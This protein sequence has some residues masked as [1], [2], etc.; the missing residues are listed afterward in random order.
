[1]KKVTLFL[2]IVILYATFLSPI[3]LFALKKIG[4]AGF[5]FLSIGVGARATGMGEAFTQVGDDVNAIFYN[6]AGIAKM[7]DK[8]NFMANRTTWVADISYNAAGLVINLENLGSFGLSVISS[9]YGDIIGTR[10]SG[11]LEGF[12][13][14]GNLD[15]GAFALS[16]AYARQMTDKFT[17]GG[18]IKYCYQHLGENLLVTNEIEEN[19]ASGF[20]YDFG[21][22]FYPGF[23]SFRLGMTITNFSPQFK[24]VEYSFQL[25]LTFKIGFAMDIL[26]LFGEHVGNSFILSV[27]AIHPRDYEERIHIGGE[28]LLMDMLAIRAGYKFNYDVE[29]LTAGIGLITPPLAGTGLA[30]K[31]DYAYSSLELFGTVNRF[32]LGITF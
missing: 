21:T 13:E 20:S 3:H 19:K 10:V 2:T 5:K 7:H 17:A 23:K 27:D 28:Y 18:Q 24:Y 25:P 29:G 31:F 16:V 4:Q 11:T 15:V 1:M 6:P 12:E 8:I 22:I 14:T 30:V 26:D 32:S 9:S